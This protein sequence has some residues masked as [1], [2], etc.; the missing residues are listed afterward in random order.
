MP[1][2]VDHHNA[3]GLRMQTD[4]FIMEDEVD[5]VIFDFEDTV[6]MDSSGIGILMGRYKKL[7]LFGG[8]VLAIHVNSRLRKIMQM[9]GVAEFIEIME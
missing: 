8:R 4:R 2:E 5:H 9:A 6:F 7:S 1:Q 3:S